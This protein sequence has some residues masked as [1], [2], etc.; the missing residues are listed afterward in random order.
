[1]S[2]DPADWG[3]ARAARALRER[4]ISAREYVGVLVD[5]CAG[6]ADLDAFTE[7]T[8]REA[9]RGAEALD[10]RRDAGGPLAGVPLVVKDNVDVAGV[11]T[12]AG[13]PGLRGHVPVRDSGAWQRLSDAGALLLGKT[14][15]HELA[16][17]ITGA[18]AGAPTA[19]HPA[20]PDRLPGG[21]SSGTATAVAAGLAPAGVATDTGGSARIPAALCGV[22]GW[23]PTTGRY[24][25]DGVV[26]LS[27]T[28]DTVGLMARCAEDLLLL[29]A[30][31]AG[32]ATPAA[33]AA[34]S[35]APRVPRD[36]T[37]LLPSTP[38]WEALS[39]EVARVASAARDALS[40]AGVRLLDAPRALPPPRELLD[41]AL[42]VPRYETRDALREYLAGAGP[43][44][45][46]QRLLDA[47]ASPDVRELLL[48]MREGRPVPEPAYRVA[49]RAGAAMA[50]AAAGHLRAAGALAHLVPTTAL[51]A[52]EAGVGDTVECA[53]Q[54]VPTFLAYIRNTAP[55]AVF[56][57]PSVTIPAGHTR[58]G[59]PVGLQLDGAPGSD[60][61]LLHAAR[62]CLAALRAHRTPGPAPP[63]AAPGASARP[64]RPGD[65]ARRPSHGDRAGRPGPR[66]PEQQ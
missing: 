7:L 53:G 22:L 15:L 18:N 57:W 12:T 17:G 26:R 41:C 11:P 58:D 60:R 66:P 24:P 65:R 47:V 32:R 3:V 6:R 28:R 64:P 40:S 39:P 16:Y 44:Y 55:A 36:L 35:A 19:R 20:R 37:L 48:P 49:L 54:A 31:L 9:L 33:P 13:T 61:T 34:P 29:D 52:P 10:R 23:R 5:R 63:P 2:G 42:T 51:P 38:A 50:E 1:M 56:G 25:G 4:T 59:L 8:A 62:L 21:S 46:L 27:P 45:T 14:T 43:A 30:V